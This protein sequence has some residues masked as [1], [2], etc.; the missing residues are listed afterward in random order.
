MPEYVLIAGV[1]GAGKS[2][3]YYLLDDLQEM[4][5][6]NLDEIVRELGD[7]RNPVDVVKAGKIAVKKINQLFTDR[8]SFNQETTLCGKSIFRN[9]RKAKELGYRVIIHYVGVDSADM[10]KM[11]VKER[12]KRGGHDIPDKDIERRYI[13][14][15]ENLKRI[16]S[17]C[18]IIFFYDNT[19]SFN[20][21]AVY[22]TGAGMTVYP[23][24]P[25]WFKKR[26][27]RM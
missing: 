13:E 4:P 25:V 22:K 27:G 8:C 26:I 24:A 1:N 3:L 14:S 23:D 11:R 10:A 7:W 12:V 6:I 9:I 17:E 19:V 2:T 20:C 21:F 15:V 18:D 16:M 5:R